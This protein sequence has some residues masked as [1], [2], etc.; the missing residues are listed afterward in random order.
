MTTPA[1]TDFHSAAVLIAGDDP[2]EFQ[3]LCNQLARAYPPHG[4]AGERALREM[5]AAEWRLLR[6]RQYLALTLDQAI[7]TL[8][9]ADPEASVLELQRRAYVELTANNPG[10]RQFLR[11]ETRFERAFERARRELEKAAAEN[12]AKEPAA[13]STSPRKSIRPASVSKRQASVS[14]AERQAPAK[15]SHPVSQAQSG[16]AFDEPPRGRTR[17]RPRASMTS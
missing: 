7:R 11:F 13:A 12:A 5:A 15:V 14:L 1:R 2:L 10:F 17:T 16:S 8:A 4:P 6:V 3:A 9:A